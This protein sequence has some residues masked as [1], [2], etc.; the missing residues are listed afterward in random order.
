MDTSR[1]EAALERNLAELQR[2]IINRRAMV[3]ME[4]VGV[5]NDWL[6]VI[7]YALFNDYIAHCI[8]VF[9]RS[10]GSASFWYV[11]ESNQKP[12]NVFASKHDIDLEIFERLTTKLKHVRDKTHFHID[13]EGVL[14]P[15]AVWREA[16]LNGE[17]LATSIDHMWALLNAARQA[18]GRLPMEVPPYDDEFIRNLTMAVE[19][20]RLA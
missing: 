9:E 19:E 17:E 12:I 10:A 16:D 2:A 8:K 15:K 14:D 18:L 3:A 5:S 7:Y 6:K 1:Y 20:G 4:S 11:Y 13:R